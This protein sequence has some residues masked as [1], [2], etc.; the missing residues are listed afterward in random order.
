MINRRETWSLT[1]RK[2]HM[3]TGGGAIISG[4]KRSNKRLQKTATWTAS[5]YAFALRHEKLVQNLC[6]R[7]WEEANWRT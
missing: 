6:R 4:V 1:P 7:N 3:E 2:C 5:E